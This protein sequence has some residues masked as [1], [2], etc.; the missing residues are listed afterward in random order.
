MDIL[1]NI[2]ELAGAHWPF[3]AATLILAFIG[4]VL[5]GTVWTREHFLKWRLLTPNRVLWRFF[6]W[7]RK[8]LPIHPVVAGGLLGLVPGIPASPQVEGTTA[9]VLYFAFAGV[10]ST[11]AF[12]IVKAWAKKQGIDLNLSGQSDPPSEKT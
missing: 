5:K 6:W 11:W 3:V 9:L 10:I 1:G 7:G 12:A 4:Q 8:T 2:L